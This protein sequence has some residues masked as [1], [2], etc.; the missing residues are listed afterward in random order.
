[1]SSMPQ[2]ISPG[3]MSPAMNCF[4]VRS[5]CF[6]FL[7]CTPVIPSSYPLVNP[8]LKKVFENQNIEGLL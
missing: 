2:P 4:I 1:M 7:R 6:L 3:P 5:C 8:I